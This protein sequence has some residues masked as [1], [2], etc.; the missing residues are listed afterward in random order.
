MGLTFENADLGGFLS[1]E[2]LLTG[3][4]W[5]SRL[6]SHRDRKDHIRAYGLSVT[7]NTLIRERTTEAISAVHKNESRTCGRRLAYSRAGTAVQVAATGRH[8]GASVESCSSA[9]GHM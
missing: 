8:F 9:H 2:G 5:H 1:G 3:S 6:G 7:L 4:T